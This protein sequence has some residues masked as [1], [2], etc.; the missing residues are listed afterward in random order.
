VLT[1]GRPTGHLLAEIAPTST[2]FTD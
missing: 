2:I 1:L